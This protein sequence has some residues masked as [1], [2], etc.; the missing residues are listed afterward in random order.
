[1]STHYRPPEI[2]ILSAPVTSANLRN[3]RHHPSVDLGCCTPFQLFTNTGITHD[4]TVCII[5][6]PARGIGVAKAMIRRSQK[7]FLL[8]G[9]ASD[10][11]SIFSSLEPEWARN[12]AQISLPAGNGALLFSKPYSSYMEMCEYLEAWSR[13]YF[14]IFHLGSGLQ[15][16]IEVLNLLSTVGQCLIICDSIPQ[17]IR[18]SDTRTITPREFMSQMSYFL[19]FSTGVATR[20]LID[21]L[22]TYQYEKVS[23]TVSVNSY[24]GSSFFHPFHGHR[25]HGVS[26]GQTRTMEYKKSVFEMDDLEKIFS[27][28]RALMYNA[29]TNGVFLAQI[30]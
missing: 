28:G 27:D 9:T 3:A 6:N 2:S 16:G 21:L 24:K 8:L 19:V 15:I 17:S 26:T 30:V 7:P 12:S 1:M 5:G 23:N 14:L 18:N 10:K 11:D 25:G 29:R 4:G 13:D 22:P 20:D